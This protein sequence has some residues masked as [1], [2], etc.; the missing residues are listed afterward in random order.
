MRVLVTGAA[1]FIG[2]HLA[3]RLLSLGHQVTGID[4]LTHYYSPQLKQARLKKLAKEPNAGNFLFHRVDLADR[5]ALSRIFLDGK[6]THVVNMAAQAG[7]RYSLENPQAYLESN[8]TG[9]G[10]LLEE[11]RRHEIEHLVYASSSS[12]YGLNAERPYSVH[13]NVDHPLSLYAATKKSNELMAHSYSH[14]FNLPATGLRFFTVYGPWGRPD[15]ALYL[16][17]DAI[18][19]GKPVSL[20]NNGQLQRDFTYIDDIVE[21]VSLVLDKP[22][23]PNPDFDAARPDPALSSAPWR[24]FNIGNNN[25]V[26][27]NEFVDI[28]EAAVGKKAIRN[29]LPMQPGDALSTW[30]DV[31][32]FCQLT[33][34]RPATRLEDGIGAYVKWHKVYYGTPA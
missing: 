31:D 28:I 19:R 12:V 9:F 1:G 8:I 3:R 15:M 5:D 29:Y 14:L 34:F 25:T 6:F 4:N 7:V 13:Q 26:G 33:G 30:A 17:T 24:I 10:N 2:F 22:P 20:F 21:G 32:D 11:C 16:F 23:A 27:L 18:L